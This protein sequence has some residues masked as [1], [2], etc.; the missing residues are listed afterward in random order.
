MYCYLPYIVF[1]LFFFLTRMLA[2]LYANQCPFAFLINK[3]KKCLLLKCTHGKG[4]F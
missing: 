1:N 2:A 4:G 3:K